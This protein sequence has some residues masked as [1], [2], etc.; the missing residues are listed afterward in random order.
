MTKKLGK[1]ENGDFMN[2]FLS[3]YREIFDVYVDLW[4]G[5]LINKLL[6]TYRSRGMIWMEEKWD[7]Q[8][9]LTGGN[10]V[11]NQIIISSTTEV[12]SSYWHDT[13]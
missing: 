10:E 3:E 8:H 7:Q 11:N 6:E 1:S 12:Y 5:K 9:A 13:G 4:R 2:S